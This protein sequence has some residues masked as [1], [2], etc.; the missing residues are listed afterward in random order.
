MEGG[1]GRR[2]AEGGVILVFG[3]CGTFVATAPGWT[4]W[5][6]LAM[7]FGATASVSNF[8]R[9]GDALQQLRGLLLLATGHYVD[10]F[11]CLEFEE[12]GESAAAA[13]Q[14]LFRSQLNR[15]ALRGPALDGTAGGLFL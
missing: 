7:N 6:H 1:D 5:Y 3:Q 12:V 9:G 14:E 11:N 10:D 8:N 15:G 2:M 13:F 4:F